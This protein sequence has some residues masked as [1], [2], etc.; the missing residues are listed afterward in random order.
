MMRFLVLFAFLLLAACGGGGNRSSAPRPGPQTDIRQCLSGL[1]RSGVR[2]RALP[3]RYFGNGCQAAGSVQ[4]LDVGVPVTNLTALTCPM[5]QAVTDWTRTVRQL[6]R[7]RLGA[8][9]VRIESFGSYACR[10]VNNQ[11]GGRLS[12][13]ARA[14]AV[15]IAAFVLADGR[16]ISVEKGWSGPDGRVRDFLRMAHRAGCRRFAIGLGPDSDRFHY[17]HFHFD[18]GRGPYCR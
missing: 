7:E 12:E 10:P 15:D 1:E 4:L 9:V 8:D 16:R 14:N 2:Y 6:A 17:N 3:D 13:H 11:M 18:M 5:A